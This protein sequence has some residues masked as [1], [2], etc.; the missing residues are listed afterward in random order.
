MKTTEPVMERTVIPEITNDRIVERT[1]PWGLI[2]VTEAALLTI[3]AGYAATYQDKVCAVL[4]D[5]GWKVR[6]EFAV[7]YRGC[8]SGKIDIVAQSLGITLALELDNRSP[9]GKSILKLRAVT[10]ETLITGILLRNP[11]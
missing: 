4:R 7:S 6:R 2:P 3:R 11:K 5:L 10:A 1:G 8:H 9:R